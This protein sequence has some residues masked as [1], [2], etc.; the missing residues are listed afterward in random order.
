[1]YLCPTEAVYEQVLYFKRIIKFALEVK[2]A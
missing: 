1:M 2:R